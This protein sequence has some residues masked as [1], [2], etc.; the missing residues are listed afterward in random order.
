MKAYDDGNRLAVPAIVPAKH[1]LYKT[2][3]MDSRLN[4]LALVASIA[5]GT[6]EK[7]GHGLNPAQIEVFLRKDFRDESQDFLQALDRVLNAMGASALEAERASILLC[8]WAAPHVDDSYVEQAF[9]SLVLH[10]GP[11]PYIMQALHTHVIEGPHGSQQIE[12]STRVL[13]VGDVIVFDP[14]TAHFTVPKYPNDEQLL[15]LLQVCV[16]DRTEEDREA[17]L[18]RFPVADG[19]VDQYLVFEHG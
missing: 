17:L 5:K 15:I 13:T 11:E 16:N 12:T 7:R 9:V 18:K 8:E 3:R 19:D 2:N 10:T 1:F 6:L 14:T 4:D